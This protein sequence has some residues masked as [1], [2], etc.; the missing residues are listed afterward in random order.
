MNR[1][2]S[3]GDEHKYIVDANGCWLWQGSLDEKGYGTLKRG[4]KVW[5]AYKYF[6]VQKYGL[7]SDGLELAH[8]KD[9]PRKCCNP[10]HVRPI[11]HKQNLREG[12][13]LVWNSGLEAQI[14]HARESGATYQEIS[15]EYNIPIGSIFKVLHR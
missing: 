13:G 14:K 8:K 11:T 10:D 5:R 15:D 3:Y 9:C 7:V 1:N 4:G 2:F 12:K 6:Y